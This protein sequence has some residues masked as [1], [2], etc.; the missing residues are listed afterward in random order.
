MNVSVVGATGYSGMELIRLLSSHPTFHLTAVY[1]SS[2][3]GN[4]LD[5]ENRQHF[6]LIP[7]VLSEVDPGLIAKQSELVFLAMPSGVS[8]ELVPELY[9]KGLK[10]IDLSGDH[11][12]KSGELYE[13]WYKGSPPSNDLLQ[14][15]VYGL[16]EWNR[17]AIRES[18]LI[19]N[20]GCYP[21][22]TLL[23][24]V[25]LLSNELIESSDI[26]IDAKSGV[27]G[28]GKKSNDS[29]HYAHVNDN[30]SIY[31]VHQH[32]HI[33]EIEQQLSEWDSELAPIMF[34]TH[35]IPMTRGIMVT[36][37][38][39]VKPEVTAEHIHNA[40][41][42]AYQNEF[43]IRYRGENSFSS[44]KEVYGSNFCDIGFR[45]D[46]RTGRVTVVSVIDNLVKG[47]AGQAIHNANIMMGLEETEGLRFY[48]VYP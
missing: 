2:S 27:S 5:H 32:Q 9:K 8:K 47:A 29:K 42:T 17:A 12:L 21:T 18:R 11:R 39:K 44:T 13:K 7:H 46:E 16:S 35:L 24:L 15:S 14:N 31:K 19:A 48:P 41:L 1:S 3:A 10:I 23:G 30:L 37:H 34:T 36:M 40:F 28:A 33:P 4:R 38:A 20:P 25:P 6:G 45:M 22:A 43:F 26:I